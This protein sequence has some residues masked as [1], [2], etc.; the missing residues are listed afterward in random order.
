MFDYSLYL[1]MA[2]ILRPWLIL[3]ALLVCVLVSLGTFADAYPPKPVSPDNNAPPE[4]W[5]RYNTALRHYINLITRQRWVSQHSNKANI[6]AYWVWRKHKLLL[7][8]NILITCPFIQFEYKKKIK[9]CPSLNSN[10]ILLI[11]LRGQMTTIA[12]VTGEVMGDMLTNNEQEGPH[13][14]YAPNSPLYWRFNWNGSS[15][16]QTGVL[17]SQNI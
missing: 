7:T 15:S 14:V 9:K 1:Q 17:T 6:S 5:A 3:V 16:G 4:E 11:I 13:T 12:K 8:T 2:I 10:Q